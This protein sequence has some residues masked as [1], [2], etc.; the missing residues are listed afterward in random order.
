MKRL[1]PLLCLSLAWTSAIRADNWCDWMADANSVLGYASVKGIRD[2]PLMTELINGNDNIS[3]FTAAIN[4]WTAVNLDS[5]TDAWFGVAGQDDAIFVLQG[6][7]NLPIIRGRLGAIEKFR[8]ETPSNAE[9]TVTMPDDKKPGKFN[10][11]AF[12]NPTIM[13]FG[14]PHQVEAF[15][16]NLTQKRKHAEAA[17]FGMLGK[18]SHMLECVLLKFPNKDG[19]TPRI[20]VENTRVSMSV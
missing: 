12:I 7:F 15:L 10:T 6:T 14:A 3:R 1:V 16:G 19:K 18:P 5:V 8:I 9:F 20:I 11:A 13:A 2:I 4:E 17:D